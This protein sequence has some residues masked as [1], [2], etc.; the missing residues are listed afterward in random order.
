MKKIEFDLKEDTEK[1]IEKKNEIPETH[2]DKFYSA[3]DFSMDY[4]PWMLVLLANMVDYENL[5]DFEHVYIFNFFILF[6]GDLC[7]RY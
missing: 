7:H 5:D 4:M 1:N 6:L 3:V 2:I